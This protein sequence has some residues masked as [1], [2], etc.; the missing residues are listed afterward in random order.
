MLFNAPV[1]SKIAGTFQFPTPRNIEQ[2]YR[3][4]H[5]GSCHP[6]EIKRRYLDTDLIR[7]VDNASNKTLQ[8]R[9]LAPTFNIKEVAY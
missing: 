5:D 3:L 8:E 1:L 7:G 9:I 6:G 4:S 2:T